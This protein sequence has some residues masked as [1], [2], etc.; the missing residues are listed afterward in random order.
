M[1]PLA[2]A[3]T[4]AGLGAN[5]LATGLLL[6]FNPRSAAVRWYAVFLCA[7][8]L[9]LL[10]SGV[11]ATGTT[12]DVWI[13]LLAA[14]VQLLPALFLAAAFAQCRMRTSLSVAAAAAGVLL[15]PV[16]VPAL[17]GEPSAITIAL[18]A[19]GWG[20]GTIVQLRYDSHDRPERRTTSR[21]LRWLLVLPPVV[22]ALGIAIGA[23]AFFTYVMPLVIIGVHFGIFGGIVWLNYYDIEVRAAR[24]GEIAS[25]AA[26]AERLAA[27]GEMSASIAHEIRNP[28]AGIRSLAQ[29]M[30]EESIDGAR[31]KRYAGVIVEEAGRLDRIVGDLLVLARRGTPRAHT[32]ELTALRTLFDDV[33]LLTTSRAERAGIR[34]V[35]RAHNLTAAAPREALAQALLNIVLNAI[36]HSPAG[37]TVTLEATNV[38]GTGVTPAAPTQSSAGAAVNSVRITVRDQGPG[39]PPAERDR[40]FEPFHTMGT[41][42]TGLGLSVVRRLARELDWRVDVRDAP[43]GGAEFALT[44]GAVESRG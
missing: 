43:G 18:H 12:N 22:A 2:I 27:V 10:G 35:T 6:L 15:L 19:G 16:T 29:R 39:V 17:F 28:L 1:D 3:I 11:I 13:I 14:G 20:G 36:A 8:S 41:D 30:A 44:I 25:R 7:I 38:N 4:F 23:A 24:T 21:L 31:T 9:W 32:G 42:G 34:L 33:V 26:E 37:G 5:I 40:I